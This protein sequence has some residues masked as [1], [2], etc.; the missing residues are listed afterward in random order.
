MIEL[1]YVWHTCISLTEVS[2]EHNP[3]EEDIML[4]LRAG[5]YKM[6]LL[7]DSFKIVCH[8]VEMI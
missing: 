1:G 2:M 8:S 6:F 4:K 3:S 5:E 7:H